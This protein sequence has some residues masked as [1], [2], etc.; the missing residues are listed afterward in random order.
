MHPSIGCS[1]KPALRRYLTAPGPRPRAHLR[2]AAPSIFLEWRGACGVTSRSVCGRH[3]SRASPG[4]GFGRV[5]TGACLPVGWG[6]HR[7]EVGLPD[8]PRPIRSWTTLPPTTMAS[9]SIPAR[10]AGAIAVGSADSTAKSESL[11]GSSEPRSASRKAA[12]AEWTV[13]ARHSECREGSSGGGRRGD[14]RGCTGG[15]TAGRMS[16]R[17]RRRRSDPGNRAGT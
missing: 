11:P 13:G 3:V 17:P 6:L 8:H 9:T 10:L 1:P 12:R 7:P 14:L 2:G 16:R 15:R 4:K 5:I